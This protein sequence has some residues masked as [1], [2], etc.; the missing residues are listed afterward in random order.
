MSYSLLT[1][2]P[3][4]GLV[5]LRGPD[6]AGFLQ[7]LVTNDIER[8]RPGEAV[9]AGLLTPQGKILFDFLIYVRD[10]QSCWLDCARDQVEELVKRLTMY[11]LRAKVEIADRSAEFAVGA[12]WGDEPREG[13]AA[14]FATYADPR[15]APLGERIILKHTESEPANR[16]LAASG[17]TAYHRHRISLAVPQGGLDYPYGET[18]PHE[19]CYDDLDGVDFNKGCY[20][21]QEVVSRMYHRGIAKTRIAAIETSAPLD[22]GGAEIRAGEVPVGTIGSMDGVH[23]IAMVRLDR[24]AHAI[25]NGVDLRV[26][27][28]T[29][30][31]R[32]PP[33]ASYEVPSLG[34]QP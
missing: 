7:G 24:V 28:V 21:G 9:F 6:A 16:A 11:R 29:V 32:R 31:V 5:E 30:S 33:W 8:A 2:L 23:G 4:R 34:V 22:G 25:E 19:A 14:F 10:P 3:D 27:D 13:N 15:Y 1:L 18:F 20:V 17:E 12:A 26:G